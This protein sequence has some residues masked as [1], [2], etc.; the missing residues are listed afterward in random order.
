MF[1]YQGVDRTG[2]QIFNPPVFCGIGTGQHLYIEAHP[3]R[4]ETLDASLTLVL[5]QDIV[6]RK[7]NIRVTQ[8][9]GHQMILCIDYNL[10][11]KIE[12][13]QAWSPP[14]QCKEYH[15][16]MAG[17]VK[18]WNF[19]DSN[20]IHGNNQAYSICIRREKGFC[21]YSVIPASEPDRFKD[22]DDIKNI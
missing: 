14:H 3:Y 21:G 6:K 19:D 11:S 16:G 12:C 5:G 1:N 17:T 2:A 7:W 13:G 4:E 20:N 9:S 22:R 8:V 10:L 18:S 15:T